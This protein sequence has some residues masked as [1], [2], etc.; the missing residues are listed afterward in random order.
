MVESLF[1]S[2]VKRVESE[3]LFVEGIAIADAD[4]ILLEHHFTPDK[5][6][7]I[8]S[9]TKSYMSTAAG[10]A[11]SEGKLSL[12]D[13]L[14]DFF[15]E[16]LPKDPQPELFDITLRDLLTMSSG[17]NHSYLMSS[18]RRAGVGVPDYVAYMLSQK[19]EVKPGSA[20]LYSTADSILAG[21]MIEKA[22]GM[23]MSEYLYKHILAPLGQGFPIW[24]NDAEG[25]PVG[26]AG[27]FLKLSDMMKLGQL[28]LAGGKWHGEQ[29]VDPAWIKEA[30]RC[31]IETP[32]PEQ[33]IWKCGYGY[34]FWMSPYE[35]AYR[36]DGMYGQITTVLPDKGLVVAI[37][38]PEE[39][40]FSK[41]KMVLH[42]E[43]LTAL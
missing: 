37:Q 9:H 30:T 35:G 38:C 6:R 29:L 40:D 32:N 8:Y 36:A 15:P 20:F 43:L 39:G 28:Y 34:Q 26:G 33:D 21:R 11:I 19:V 31:Q 25:H 27:M 3:H 18:D 17:F 10:I 13:K 14:A 23:R 5:P 41:V 12:E 1:Q 7:N 16:K 42:E 4:H 2:F 24:E 22:V